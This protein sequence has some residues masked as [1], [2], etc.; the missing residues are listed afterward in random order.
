MRVVRRLLPLGAGLGAAL[1]VASL[2]GPPAP[3]AAA[4]PVEAAARWQL[5]TPKATLVLV[6][7]N[8]G[9]LKPCGCTAPQQGG[10]ERLAAALDL[11]RRR[12][13]DNLAVVS[14]G[15]IV[16]PPAAF[17]RPLAQDRLKGELY[18]A[19]AKVLD[20]R[21]A[22]L[23]TN[24]LY[25]DALTTHFGGDAATEIDRPRPPLNV[26]PSSRMGFDPTAAAL[27][28][29][30]FRLG[31]LPVR[32]LSVVD[33]GQGDTLKAA[34]IADYVSTPATA[35]QGLQA[36]PGVLWVLAVEGG[37]SA[38]AVARDALRTL[39]PGVVVD[40][41]GSSGDGPR[42]FVPLGADPLVVSFDESGKAVGVLDL[43]PGPEGKGWTASFHAQT[44]GPDFEEPASEARDHVAGMFSV[45]RRQV[46][47]QGLLA[48]EVRREEAA[49][50]PR[51]AGSAACAKCHSGIYEDWLRTPHAKA[52][53]TLRKHDYAWDPECLTCHVVG[54][55]RQTD[56][57]WTWWAS[58]FVDP[59]TTPHLGGVGCESC[60]GPGS[61]HVAEPWRKDLFA[62]GGPNRRAPE[63]RGCTTCHDVE[64]SVGFV[65]QYPVRLEHVDHRRVP[66]ERRTHAAAK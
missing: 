42:E 47:E 2:W 34:G 20:F 9:K 64:N 15:G 55:Q 28:W 40:M 50:A 54:P 17:P 8:H 38:V 22:V 35:L 30:E 23:G 1:A 21:A 24:D 14:L 44:L 57:T 65:D 58:G 5:R 63:K 62:A 37:A 41:S 25:V 18:R 32:V 29:A 45:Y 3:P 59:D 39:G 4:A 10:L 60:H 19:V 43:D 49:E 48:L 36:N 61:A 13:K 16:P 66:A 46:R 27:P 51:F 31:D 53:R 12:S 11:L 52:L 7:R 6:G 56:G 26:K 33:E